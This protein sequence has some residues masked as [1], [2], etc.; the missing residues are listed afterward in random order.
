MI[1][2]VANPRS[3]LE[4]VFVDLKKIKMDF[5]NLFFCVPQINIYVTVFSTKNMILPFTKIIIIVCVSNPR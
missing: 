1:H 4:S 3:V 2:S 5:V